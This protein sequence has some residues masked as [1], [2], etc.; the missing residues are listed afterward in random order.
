MAFKRRGTDAHQDKG[1]WQVVQSQVARG[2]RQFEYVTEDD[3]STFEAAGYITLADSEDAELTI[4]EA[5]IGDLVWFWQVTTIDDEQSIE[6]DKASGVLDNAFYTVTDNDGLTLTFNGL[7]FGTPGALDTTG[8]PVSGDLAEFTDANTVRGQTIAELGLVTTADVGTAA[9]ADTD[10]FATAAQGAL[11]DTALQPADVPTAVTPGDADWA[12]TT[13][14]GRFFTVH[15]IGLTTERAA[16]LPVTMDSGFDGTL[17]FLANAG[18]NSDNVVVGVEDAG[19]G[20]SSFTLLPGQ[21]LIVQLRESDGQWFAIGMFPT[22]GLGALATA[23][24]IG[25][26]S[27]TGVAQWRI[28]MR[29]S[30]GSGELEP[31]LISSGLSEKSVPVS[32]DWVMVEDGSTHEYVSVQLANLLSGGY[33]SLIPVEF[34]DDIVLEDGIDDWVTATGYTSGDLVKNSDD[35]ILS[36][37]STDTSGATE[38][39]TAGTLDDGTITWTFVGDA[40]SPHGKKL[41][42]TSSSAIAI[43]AHSSIA[44]NSNWKIRRD[45]TG[46]VTV[47]GSG[48][49]LNG[50]ASGAG[51]VISEVEYT[52]IG[53]ST[54]LKVEGET[55][56]VSTAATMWTWTGLTY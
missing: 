19:S 13:A 18:S 49:T 23:D 20:T 1:Y 56:E 16:T 26:D 39:T 28:A 35:E 36:A 32:T 11:A 34:T 47:T 33:V 29:V 55:G 22:S 25:L 27:T 2:S 10:D 38:P 14:A 45:G 31:V 12:Y 7:T 48:L 50:G 41:Y 24:T 43:L 37:G 30:S 46:D 8:T 5:A 6:D 15:W 4:D 52:R 51:D 53:S 42:T 54:D 21:T 17:G 9:A 40:V 3:R 44:D